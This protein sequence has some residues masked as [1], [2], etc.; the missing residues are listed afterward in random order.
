MAAFKFEFESEGN[1]GLVNLN[2]TEL[3]ALIE[4]ALLAADKDLDYITLRDDMTQKA[5]ALGL[6][7]NE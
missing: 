6:E 1:C 2:E 5:K 3:A 4:E 7:V